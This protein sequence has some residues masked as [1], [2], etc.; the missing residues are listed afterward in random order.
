MGLD[1]ASYGG[2]S[3]RSGFL[4]SAAESGA[5]IWKL[6]DQSRH[7]SS[8]PSVAMCGAS[9]CSKITREPRS[10]EAVIVPAEG[11]IVD[12]VGPCC[13]LQREPSLRGFSG[14]A[15]QRAIAEAIGGQRRS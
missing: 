14:M 4:T 8:T 12:A 1:P 7:K 10:C 9:T 2:H 6:A 3:L 15:I 11:L 5:S 13:L